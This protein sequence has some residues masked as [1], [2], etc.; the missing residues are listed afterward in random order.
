MN[1]KIRIIPSIASANMLRIGDEIDRLGNIGCLHLDIEDGNF[2]PS[3]TFGMDTVRAIAAYTSFELD[4]HLMVTNPLDYVENLIQ[5]GVK[6]ICA[7]MEALPY[8]AK[9]LGKVQSLGGKA[10]LA[11][12]LK[13]SVEELEPFISQ[14]D[15]VLLLTNEPDFAGLK[16]R[17]YCYSKIEKARRLLPERISL[18]VDGGVTIDLLPRLIQ[19]GVDTV[20]MGRAIFNAENPQAEYQRMIAA[21]ETSRNP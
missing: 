15:Y 17:E 14:L 12:N 10:G 6:T 19:R 5:C 21:M 1:N 2:C 9:F 7:Q 13:T 18:W 11:L 8:P 4:V 20:I 3:M 16:F